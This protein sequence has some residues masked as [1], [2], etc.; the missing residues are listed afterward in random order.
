[1]FVRKVVLAAIPVVDGAALAAQAMAPTIG[2][3]FRAF[4]TALAGLTA[5]AAA[6]EG[7]GYST[8]VGCIAGIGVTAAFAVTFWKTWP[9]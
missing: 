9:H 3:G 5:Y 2:F 7:C 1:M 8:A 4:G 6:T